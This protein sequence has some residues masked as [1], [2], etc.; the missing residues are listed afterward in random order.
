MYICNFLNLCFLRY[1]FLPWL[2]CALITFC[3][4]PINFSS[5]EAFLPKKSHS[6][7]NFSYVFAI[8]RPKR[9]GRRS[10]R[11]EKGGEGLRAFSSVHRT[12][13]TL[14]E[15]VD[16]IIEM[17]HPSKNFDNNKDFHAFAKLSDVNLNLT[18]RM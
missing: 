4:F 10:G 1:K 5:S 15:I 13:Y 14:K 18:F 16:I 9:R 11:Q 3:S 7:G 8:R 2:H 17:D 12:T 6:N